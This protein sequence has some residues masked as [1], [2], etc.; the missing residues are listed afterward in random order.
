MKK[1]WYLT[2]LQIINF[3]I[4][5]GCPVCDRNH[6]K[7]SRIMSHGQQANSEWDYL[8]VWGV[9]LIVMIALYLTIKYLVWP[10]E[11]EKTHIKRSILGG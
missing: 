3:K 4:L 8:I 7:A 9:A 5:L 10:G 1:I 11:R 6:S 2:L